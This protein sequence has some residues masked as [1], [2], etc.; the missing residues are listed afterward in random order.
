MGD[1]AELSTIA[2]AW[3]TIAGDPTVDVAEALRRRRRQRGALALELAASAVAIVAAVFFWLEAEGPL[4]RVTAAVMLA[5]GFVGGG[6]ALRQRVELS[7]WGDWTPRGVLA[8]RLQECDVALATGWFGVVSVVVLLV[9]CALLTGAALLLR[10]SQ[11]LGV[12][13]LYIACVVASG[14][15]VGAWSARVIWT[16]RR[17][18]ARLRA[19]ADQ[20]GEDGLDASPPSGAAP[21]SVM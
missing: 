9:F 4:L 16:R 5:T 12:Y 13:R 15:V 10:D 6:V 20:L 7:S 21:A 17:E 14:A 3:H 8:F 2:G 19:L 11:I 18:R 1:D